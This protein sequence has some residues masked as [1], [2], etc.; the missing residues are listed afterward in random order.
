MPFIAKQ[1]ISTREEGKLHGKKFRTA[2]EFTCDQCNA[3]YVKSQM[4]K[5]KLGLTFC[6]LLCA[7]A[8]QVDGK[9]RHIKKI[10][11][12][13][14]AKQQQTMI[15][16]HGCTGSFA[17]KEISSRARQTM[18]DQYGTSFPQKLDEVKQKMKQTNVEKWGH[19]CSIHSLKIAP[20][21]DRVEQV[22]KTFE[23]K[24]AS[25]TLYSSKPEDR[26]KIA[27]QEYWGVE[28]VKIHPWFNK[29]LLD[30][31]LHTISTYVQV[32]GMYWH[33]I[34]RSYEQLVEGSTPHKKWIR[35][36]EQDRWFSSQNTYKLVR[37]TDVEINNVKSDVELLTLLK[38]KNLC[39]SNE[40][41]PT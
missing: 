6:S 36:R 29:W 25:G 34:D 16:R 38:E 30:F 37:I 28:N 14:V 39:A 12:P 32:D 41:Q 20:H 27:L 7:N 10:P 26:V 31:Y 13:N 8:S 21:I 24:R 11:I 23:T 2:Y 9:L 1:F 40:K 15:E 17:S 19:E 35:D 22:R 33:G 18:L 5:G 4:P 3:K